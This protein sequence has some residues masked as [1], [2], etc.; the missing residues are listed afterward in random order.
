MKVQMT[1]G[2]DYDCKDT[3]KPVGY[4]IVVQE[5]SGRVLEDYYAGNA[6]WESTQRIPPSDPYAL[7]KETLLRYAKQTAEEMVEE[8]QEKDYTVEWS[9]GVCDDESNCITH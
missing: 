4:S 3:S 8:L 9:G 6:P 1:V 2:L 5:E 7:D